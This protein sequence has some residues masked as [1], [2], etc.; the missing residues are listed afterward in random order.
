MNFFLDAYF[1]PKMSPFTGHNSPSGKAKNKI[2]Y[3]IQALELRLP[4]KVI[5]LKSKAVSKKR[6]GLTQKSIDYKDQQNYSSIDLLV[7]ESIEKCLRESRC[8]QR[9]Q[10]TFVYLQMMRDIKNSMFHKSLKLIR[11]L[12]LVWKAIF[13]L[14]IWRAWLA[15]QN[16]PE[17]DHFITCNTYN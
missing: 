6:H 13:F 10:G 4:A 3:A 5:F 9:T 14:R 8:S 11:R 7:S 16:L 1:K 2:A 17:G 15:E 12:Y